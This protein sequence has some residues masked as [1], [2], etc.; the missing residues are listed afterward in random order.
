LSGLPLRLRLTLVFAT[1]MAVVLAAVGAFVYFRVGGELLTSVDQSLRAGATEAIDHVRRGGLTDPRLRLVDP[2]QARGETLAQVLDGRGRVLRSTTTG[3]APLVSRSTVARVLGGAKVLQTSGL[4]G[5][6]SEWRVY[7]LP[8]RSQ[9]RT[10][11]LVLASSL[12]SRQETLDRLLT[13]LGVAGPIA[14]L[15]A[16]LAGYGLAAATLR[17]VESMRRRAAEIS[18]STPGLRLP[19]PRSRDEFARLAET[20]NDMLGRLEAAFEHERRFVADASHELRTPLA[21]LRTELELALRR[22]RTYDEQR[23]ALESAAEETERLTRLAEDLLLIARSD[24]G[25]L[26]IRR[27]HVVVSELLQTVAERFAARAGASGREILVACDPGVVVDADPARLEQAIGNLVENALVHGAGRI[28]LSEQ[29]R[30]L[31]VEIHV[32]DEGAGFP[33]G[34]AARAFDRFSRANDVRGSGGTGLGLS[35]VDLIAR[36]H[37]GETGVDTRPG[38]G[39]DVWIRL[40]RGRLDAVEERRPDLLSTGA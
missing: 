35:I 9:G 18:A 29:A 37:G 16:S 40:E 39:G 20:L 27:E 22:P 36:A 38:G 30:G 7:A 14:L 1:A 28:E 5:R 26:P 11:V 24:Q 8:V 3:L 15:L 23:A 32:T 13:E 17:H 19:V 4:P 21:L 10:V 12:A 2:D 31:A 34:F 33:P 25:A 6:K